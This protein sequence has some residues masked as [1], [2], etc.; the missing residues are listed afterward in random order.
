MACA[1]CLPVGAQQTVSHSPR[2]KSL[3]VELGGH[4]GE[5]PVMLIHSGNFIEISFDDLQASY[6]RYTY[7]ITHC[8][9]DWNQ[10]DLLTSEYMTGFNDQRIDDYEPAIGTEMDYCHYSFTLPNSEVRLLVSGNYVVDI[11]EDGE[12]EPVARACFSVVEPHVGI[13]MEVSGNTDIDT[14][15]SHQQVSFR[16]NYSGYQVSNPV[17]DLKPVVV[18]NHRWDT[19]VTDLKPS[20]MRVNQLVYEHN[21]NLIFEA[22]NEYRRFEILDEYVP[23]MR[24]DNMR[25]DDPYYTATLYTDAQRVN[26]LFDKDQ[27]GRYYVRNGDNDNNDTESDYFMTRFTLEMPEIPGGSVYLNGDFTGNQY[28]DEYKMVYNIIDH[29]Y[30]LVTPLKQGS[31]NYQYLFVRDG[32]SYGTPRN[33]EGCFHQTQNEYYIYVYHR[34]V[35]LRYDKLVGFVRN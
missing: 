17:S 14:W 29:K 16:I 24:V 6:Q 21:R 8:N 9:A 26:Y 2:I 15:E 25:F 4:W 31:Y 1:V 12:D 10:S 28:T 27:D 34:P 23:T 7:T 3:Q 18:Q 5:P 13:D 33:T 11:F 30:E 35:G 32:D 22:G 20:Y 19:Q